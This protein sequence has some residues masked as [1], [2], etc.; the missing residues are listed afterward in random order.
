MHETDSATPHYMEDREQVRAGGNWTL[1]S[2]FKWPS[3]MAG[4]RR[5]VTRSLT[6]AAASL[7][8]LL[9]NCHQ[10]GS[11]TTRHHGRG[12]RKWST[13]CPISWISDTST[14]QC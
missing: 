6:G 5:K 11:S 12:V 13:K 4:R 9:L 7:P 2:S 8:L 10:N 3:H 1:A 14:M